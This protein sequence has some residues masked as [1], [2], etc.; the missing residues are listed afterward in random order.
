MHR[1]DENSHREIFIVGW[2]KQYY[3]FSN[4]AKS[5][6]R[7]VSES[8]KGQK[9]METLLHL[10]NMCVQSITSGTVQIWY[11]QGYICNTTLNLQSDNQ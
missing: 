7:N 1:Y 4:C 2:E 10:Y 8:C 11:G 6:K 9:T 5:G 3:R